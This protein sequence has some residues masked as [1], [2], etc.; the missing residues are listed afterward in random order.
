MP[1]FFPIGKKTCIRKECQSFG[2]YEQHCCGAL[3]N[4]CCGSVTIAGWVIVGVLA[5]SIVLF[6][7]STSVLSETPETYFQVTQTKR[8]HPKADQNVSKTAKSPSES[9]VIFRIRNDRLTSSLPAPKNV[10][11]VLTLVP[12]TVSTGT[13]AAESLAQIVADISA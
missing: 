11:S 12:R 7:G 1:D 2:V 5:A 4:D 13:T 9:K 3:L 10:Y 6:T 8:S